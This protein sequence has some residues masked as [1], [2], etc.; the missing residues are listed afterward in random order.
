MCEFFTFNFLYKTFSHHPYEQLIK[1]SGC[2]S[3]WYAQDHQLGC[4]RLY[5]PEGEK[6]FDSQ[7]EKSY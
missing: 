4:G 5:T 7:V 6:I 3:D 2:R 1:R